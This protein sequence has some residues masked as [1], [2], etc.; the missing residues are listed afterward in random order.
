M[1]M[2]MHRPGYQ[3]PRGRELSKFSPRRPIARTP[4][5]GFVSIDQTASLADQF[6]FTYLVAHERRRSRER[7]DN[8]SLRGGVEE[9]KTTDR[10]LFVKPSI[11]IFSPSGLGHSISLSGAT[12]VVG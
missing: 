6:H 1:R 8:C 4:S 7:L 2:R 9:E 3:P 12:S 5:F 11:L 10:L